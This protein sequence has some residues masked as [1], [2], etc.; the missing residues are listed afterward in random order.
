MEIVLHARTPLKKKGLLLSSRITVEQVVAALLAGVKGTPLEP[1]ATSDQLGEADFAVTLHPASGFVAFR[2]IEDHV[3]IIATTSDIGPGHHAF[4]VSLLESAAGRLGVTWEWDDKTGYVKDRNFA[5]LQT[6]MAEFLKDLADAPDEHGGD[7]AEL[8]GCRINL[9]FDLGEIEAGENEVLTPIGPK[10]VVDVLRWRSLD[11]TALNRAAADFFAW[12]GEG[13]D[14]SFYRG[15]ALY[16]LW[17]EVRWAYPIDPKE[18][19]IAKRT[20]RWCKEAV[21]R[22][23]IDTAFLPSVLND[24][25]DVILAKENRLHFPRRDGVGY[26]CRMM[27]RRL[28]HGWVLTIPASL[29]KNAEASDKLQ[30]LVLQNHVLEICVSL[31]ATTS[32]RPL[33]PGEIDK[34]DKQAEFQGDTTII[35]IAARALKTTDMDEI[36]LMTATLQDDRFMDLTTRIFESLE[37]VPE[38]D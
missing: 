28:G 13:F 7:S 34:T 17:T 9:A 4:L 18:V 29:G 14:G 27:K 23:I 8:P 38:E 19:E 32:R 11:D 12:W 35:K 20:L 24:V 15:L 33:Q 3:E 37:H 36:C 21:N 22:E 25:T 16:A 26:R 31:G 30:A 5:R 10:S 6:K 1:L 2:V